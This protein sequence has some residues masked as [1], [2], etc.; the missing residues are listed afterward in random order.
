MACVFK[1]IFKK[2]IETK[3]P[4]L[5]DE[6]TG[7]GCVFTDGIYVLSGYQQN[8]CV[9]SFSGIGGKRKGDESYIVT[10]LRET[11]EELFDVENVPMTLINELK[12]LMP[13]RVCQIDG[14]VSLIYTFDDLKRI[15]SIVSKSKPLF[16]SKLYDRL[17]LTLEELVYKRKINSG[18][19]VSYLIVVPMI[20]YNTVRPFMDPAFMKDLATIKVLMPPTCF[21]TIN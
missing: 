4:V 11:I 1:W 14:Y 17:P 2:R 8:K 10:A 6:F 20:N 16:K 21:I 19:E 18:C 13:R 5:F 12:L 9:A 15:L 7:A 3:E